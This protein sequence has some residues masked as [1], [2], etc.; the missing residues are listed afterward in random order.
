MSRYRM[1]GAINSTTTKQSGLNNTHKMPVV[2]H[3]LSEK[4]QTN[5]QKYIVA[6]CCF[7]FKLSSLMSETLTGIHRTF[8]F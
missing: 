4:V 7:M 8:Q 2:K 6:R 5:M 3:D 1:Q